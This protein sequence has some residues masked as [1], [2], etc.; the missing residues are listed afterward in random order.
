[1]MPM[2]QGLSPDEIKAVAAY[3][4][5][6]GAAHVGEQ[7]AAAVSSSGIGTDPH[8]AS[9]PPIRAGKGDWASFGV[10]AASSRFQANPGFKAADARKLELKW[11]FAMTGGGQPTVIGDW[12]FVTNRSGKFYALD[13]KSG[14]VHWVVE[15]VVSRT[16]PMVIR[17]E[18]SPSGW[19]TF[20]AV[21]SRKVLAFD[22]QTGAPLWTSAVL[23][24]HP[25]SVLSGSPVVSGERLYVPISSI[26]EATSMRKE[27]VCCTFRGSLAALDLRSG[28]LLW[29][30]YMI[31]APLQEI[32]REGS[33]KV[34]W[35]PAGRGSVGVAHGRCQARPGFRG[36]GR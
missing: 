15:D 33:A 32:H 28:K 17:S 9:N 19:A 14:C 29:K 34:L 5:P 2:A 3:L 1:M 36:H 27:Y 26:E 25:S 30:S 4:T 16:T 6:N 8:C 10:D 18:L 12:L 24:D 13:A 31:R 23:E 21:A 11:S 20:V 22:A 35:G 7:P